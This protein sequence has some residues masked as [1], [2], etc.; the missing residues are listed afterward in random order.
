MLYLKD[1][2]TDL[3]CFQVFVIFF[4]S[5]VIKKLYAAYEKLL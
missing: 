3:F 1:S 2:E 5:S 4:S